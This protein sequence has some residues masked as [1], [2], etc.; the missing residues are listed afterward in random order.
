MNLFLARSN[1][2]SH[3]F[4][5]WVV[6]F[7]LTIFSVRENSIS[8]FRIQKSYLNEKTNSLSFE[9]SANSSMT[10][11]DVQLIFF[12]GF[13]PWC[14]FRGGSRIFFR[15]GCTRLLRYFNTNKPHSFFL[16]N[17][18]P[19]PRSAPALAYYK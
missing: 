7:N 1:A 8:F 16:Q 5:L 11:S 9:L 6:M 4:F 19:P 18:H 2:K 12:A 13:L 14:L 10:E 3:S 15:R 17:M